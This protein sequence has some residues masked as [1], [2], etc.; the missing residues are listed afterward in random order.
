MGPGSPNIACITA[1][2]LVG[3]SLFL[4][5]NPTYA[6]SA[7]T[8]RTAA[9]MCGTCH[10]MRGEGA[11][12]GVPRLAGQN[13]DYMA[14]ALSMFK[15]GTRKSAIMQP[16]AAG[17]SE[18]QMR[19]LAVYFAQQKAP[20]PGARSARSPVPVPAGKQLAEAGATNVAA[21]FG[22]HGA[23]GQGAGAHFPRIAGQPAQFVIDRI[24][25]FQARAQNGVPKPGT[26]TAV[27]VTMNESQVRAAAAYLSQPGGD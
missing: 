6:R 10:G 11:P 22:C 24:H 16:I 2:C 7:A 4:A 13:A 26:M 9:V 25:E 14:H 8:V 20:I 19:A 5:S 23:K 18:M 17:L 27:A 1:I 21:C 15:A 3:T 12:A